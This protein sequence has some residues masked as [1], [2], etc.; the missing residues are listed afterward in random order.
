MAMS[1]VRVAVTT[2][3]GLPPALVLAVVAL[4][5]MPVAVAEVQVLDPPSPPTEG[6]VV[7]L[8][9]LNRG[10]GSMSALATALTGAGF[11]V[12]NVDY[13][14]A[15]FEVEELATW[16]QA[17]LRRC[18]AADLRG[19]LHFVTH[20]L[21]G[22]LARVWAD[23]HP[24]QQVARSVMLSPPSRGSELVDELRDSALF[25]LVTGPAGQQLGTDTA[26][27]PLRL[28]PVRF[29]LGVI[30]GRS[31]L[32]PVYSFLIPGEDDGKVAV[33]RAGAPG[34]RDFLVVDASH[35][36]IMNGAQV[37]AQVVHFLRHGRF[38]H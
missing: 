13:P 26:S 31:T 18:C 10:A 4:L 3:R 2:V 33:A 22:V 35:P 30:T 14:S 1:S 15:R 27:V 36:F 37:H 32:N 38:R 5:A 28:S 20:S 34:M 12:L 25:K 21:G 24:D 29:E 23:R 8:H 16:L 17:E 7:L 11:R 6:T 19:A 9:G